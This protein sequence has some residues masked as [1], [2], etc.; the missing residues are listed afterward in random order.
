MAAAAWGSALAACGPLGSGA[1]SGAD[2]TRS[3]QA[4]ITLQWGGSG[5]SQTRIGVHRQQAEMFERRFPGIKVEIIPDG[6]NLDKIKAGL[7]AGTP[8]DLVSMGTRYA[9]FAQQGA[10]VP[11][12]PYVARDRYDLKDFFPAPLGAWQWRSKRWAMPF[13]G[14]LTP[15]LN[16][17]ATEESGA[18]RP[19][20]AWNDP[21]WTWA[22]FLEYCRQVA[23]QE[24]GRPVQWGFTGPQGNLRLFMAW[25]WSNGGDLF[26]KE[27]TRLTLGDP[28]ALEGLQFQA[29]LIN[30]H[31]LMPHPD[32]LSAIGGAGGPFLNNKAGINVAAV[33]G[34]AT[35][36][37]TAGLRWTV[38]A[39]PRGAKGAFIG[40]GGSGWF[41]L[42]GGRSD[43]T[44]ELLKVI[45]SPEADKL[46]ALSGEAPPARRSVARDPE[47]LT[48]K[49]APGADMKVIVDAMETAFRPDPILVQGDEI[50]AIVQNELNQAW[51]GQRSVQ[52][53][54][55]VIKARVEPLL[56]AER[57]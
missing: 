51:S 33:G 20:V 15:F 8:M 45:E 23:R 49:E 25:V 43:A 14:I 57:L 32:E 47:Y 48:P 5:N 40:G 46:L 55:D 42:K 44:W 56:K 35:Y 26:D 28:P 4:G 31:R 41:M 53:S 39:L 54:I 11:L 50:I 7:A 30:K 1:Q 10:L 17:A 18:R 52:A 2:P 16:L 22:A 21:T 24:G 34:M 3:L 27:L 36:R 13:N 29:D 12:D 19:P 6:E 38:T 37:R 9:V